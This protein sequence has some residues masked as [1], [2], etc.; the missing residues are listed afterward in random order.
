MAK[1]IKPNMQ[2]QKQ[3]QVLDL[4]FQ[5][6]AHDLWGKLM[7]RHTQAQVLESRWKELLNLRARLMGQPQQ[8]QQ[9]Q[10]QQQKQQPIPSPANAGADEST[11][12]KGEF[13]KELS[14]STKQTPTK[15]E[16]TFE[17]QEV[18]GGGYIAH[19]SC[20][21]LQKGFQG[22][23]VAPSKK[24]AEQMA[25]KV[26]MQMQ[27]KDAYRQLVGRNGSIPASGQKRK[28]SQMAEQQVQEDPTAQHG[29]KSLLTQAARLL[30]GDAL[31]KGDVMY[32]SA[33]A[34]EDASLFVATVTL[35]G[36]DP[37]VGYQGLPAPSKKLA[38]N[39]AAEAAL[40]A[41]QSQMEPLEAEHQAKKQKK[42][43]DS[44]AEFKERR[45]AKQATR[46]EAP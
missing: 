17:C 10:Q 1:T 45:A 3:P 41:L 26:A 21:A 5:Q 31:V 28:A 25:A 36:I 46:A 22:K 4:Q 19:M 6:K 42:K 40:I 13:Y 43:Q 37:T 16:V 14:K 8:K 23:E 9:Q 44:L 27:F 15:G 12:W 35:V 38:E 33:P 20:A 11:N 34:E 18:D 30:K 24:L 29:A 7:D 2:A 32:E 39:A